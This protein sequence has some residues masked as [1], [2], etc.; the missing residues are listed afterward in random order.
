MGQ[1]ARTSIFFSSFGVELRN[2]AIS[3]KQSLV[4]TTKPLVDCRT[5]ELVSFSCFLVSTADEVE[6]EVFLLL[7]HFE[8]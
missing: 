6:V 1:T 7:H 4:L 8:Y 5:C 3:N 2:P